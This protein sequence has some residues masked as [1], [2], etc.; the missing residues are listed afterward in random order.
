[1]GFLSRSALALKNRRLCGLQKEREIISACYSRLILV[2]HILYYYTEHN[3]KFTHL[4]Q[5][6]I[7]LIVVIDIIFIILFSE[8]IFI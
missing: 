2:A 8:I 6:F 1:M 3:R 4:D 5:V 7:Q